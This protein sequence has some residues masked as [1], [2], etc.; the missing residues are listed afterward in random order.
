M[1]GRFFYEWRHEAYRFGS[2]NMLHLSFF[3]SVNNRF[4]STRILTVF[5]GTGAG[6]E[7]VFAF[8]GAG[9]PFVLHCIDCRLVF[10]V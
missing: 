2:Y 1:P 7:T 3:I 10:R 5:A 6:T 8:F 9:L 4:I